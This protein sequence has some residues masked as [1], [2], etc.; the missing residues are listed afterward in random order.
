MSTGDGR[1]GG[2]G[3]AVRRGAHRQPEPIC[4]RRHLAQHEG[5]VGHVNQIV[6]VPAQ[7]GEKGGPWEGKLWGRGRRGVKGDGSFRRKTHSQIV[8]AEDMSTPR[9]AA[10][11]SCGGGGRGENGSKKSGEDGQ[12]SGRGATRAT[13]AP[14]HAKGMGVQPPWRCARAR[15][16][17]VVSRASPAGRAPT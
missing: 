16:L 3:G 1:G 2:A 15:A 6:V 4:V 8:S 11:L 14:S 10:D 5:G 9:A 13:A 7:C 17:A 12:S